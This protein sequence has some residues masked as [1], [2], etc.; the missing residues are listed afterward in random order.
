VISPDYPGDLTLVI[1]FAAKRFSRYGSFTVCPGNNFL[2]PAPNCTI[3]GGMPGIGLNAYG[4]RSNCPVN[5]LVSLPQ[6]NWDSEASNSS[7][8]S[9]VTSTLTSV[10]RSDSVIMVLMSYSIS[11]GLLTR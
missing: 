10:H 5:V 4:G 6:K 1:R 2:F 3:V 8:V 9:E 11:S 7:V